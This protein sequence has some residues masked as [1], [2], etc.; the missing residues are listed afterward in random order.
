MLYV[1]VLI[2]VTS[3]L[4][5][6]GS[7]PSKPGAISAAGAGG[8][9][10]TSPMAGSGGAGSGGAAGVTATGS[11]GAGGSASGTGGAGS[12]QAGGGGE[13]GGTGGDSGMVVGGEGGGGQGGA[14]GDDL[15]DSGAVDPSCAGGDQVDFALAGW[16]TQNGG[17]TGGKGGTTITV[18]TGAALVQ[19]LEDKQDSSMPLTILISGVITKA[20]AGVNKIDVKDVS[21]VSIIGAGDGAELDGIGI[22][23]VRASNIVVRNLKVH[24]VLSGDKDAI[25]IEG[26]ADHIWIDHCELYAEYQGVD[27]D[28]YDGLLDVKAESEYITYSWNYLHDSWK[29]ALVGSSEDDT[30]DRKLTMHH[31]FFKN[32]NS[33]MPLFRGGNGHVFNNYYLDVVDTAINSRI[34]ACLRI[35][36]NSFSNVQN[37]YVSAFSDVLGGGELVCNLLVDGTAFVYGDDVRELPT[38]TAVVPYDYAS[39]LTHPEQVEAIVMANAGVGKLDDP[40][41]F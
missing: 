10:G 8:S 34:D 1:R 4:G 38:C 33:R 36:G 22:K 9:A 21:D 15:P 32:C 6:C 24:N 2:L 5:G 31:N 19:A 39:V 11:G 41:Q 3:L 18:S 27:K 13:S 28:F 35:E 37:P 25:S 7:E 29:T 12:S 20:N 14:A 40:T 16:A 23:I 17:V 30:F 26:P